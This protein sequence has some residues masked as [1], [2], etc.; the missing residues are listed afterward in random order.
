M[1]KIV[2][3]ETKEDI[4]IDI[5][6]ATYKLIKQYGLIHT[7]I[8]KIANECN[9]GKGTFYLYFQSKEALIV[10][11]MIKQGHDSMKHFQGI[12]NGREKMS[13]EEGKEYIKYVINRN[14]TVYRYLSCEYLKKIEK[15]F[16]EQWEKIQPGH[17]AETIQA[18]LSHIEGVRGDVDIQLVSD[19]M[20]VCS[21]AFMNWNEDI[22]IP[23]KSEI[24]NSIYAHFFTLIFG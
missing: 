24:E 1:P 22:F 11:L 23:A 16:P 13:Q 21:V 18:L 5:L 8:E 17:R 19:L 4:R 14:D 7:S 20:K 9:I 12:L 15:Q 3:E 2:T 10:A 6:N